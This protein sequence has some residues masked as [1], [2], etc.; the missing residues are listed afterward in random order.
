M[1]LVVCILDWPLD[2]ILRLFDVL[3]KFSFT[4]KHGIRVALQ[5]VEQL[6]T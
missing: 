4:Y 6:K 5:V 1:L 2:N 3:T